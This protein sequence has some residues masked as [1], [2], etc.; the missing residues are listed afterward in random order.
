MCAICVRVVSTCAL[1]ARGQYTTF[2]VS[3]MSPS[4]PKPLIY[5]TGSMSFTYALI[6]RIQGIVLTSQHTPA[7]GRWLLSFLAI[8]SS[9]KTTTAA[10]VFLVAPGSVFFVTFTIVRMAPALSLILVKSHTPV[11]P[12]IT[13][14]DVHLTAQRR[15]CISQQLH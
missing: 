1:H 13:G 2:Y 14:L 8:D 11:L 3:Y 7:M 12:A 4:A 15:C 6:Y 9:N 5:W 10:C